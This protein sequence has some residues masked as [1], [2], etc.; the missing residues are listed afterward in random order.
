MASVRQ[1]ANVD[2][3]MTAGQTQEMEEVDSGIERWLCQNPR[4]PLVNIRKIV[5]LFGM[6]NCLFCA[7]LLTAHFH[8][9]HTCMRVS[10]MIAG[11]VLRVESPIFKNGSR[12]YATGAFPSTSVGLST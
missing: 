7:F 5:N 1:D 8:M 10:K 2:L 4:V 9:Q 11:N 3:D 6:F 12:N